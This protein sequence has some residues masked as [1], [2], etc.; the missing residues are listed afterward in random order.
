MIQV[1]CRNTDNLMIRWISGA[2]TPHEQ[3]GQIRKHK[4]LLKG[5]D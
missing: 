5:K 2:L 4:V 1:T 3:A